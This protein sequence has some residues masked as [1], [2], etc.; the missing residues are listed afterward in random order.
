MATVLIVGDIVGDDA[1]NLFGSHFR[2]IKS[3]QRGLFI[4]THLSE[5]D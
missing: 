2:K 1:L 5:L 4:L 3:P